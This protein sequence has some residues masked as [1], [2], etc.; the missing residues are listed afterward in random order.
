[1]K[2]ILTLT[3]VALIALFAIPTMVQAADTLQSKIDAATSGETITLD[4][5]YI[6][7]IVIKD[8]K[9]ITIDLSEFDIKGNT[10]NTI[11]VEIGSTLVIKGTTGEIINDN[12]NVALF[13]NGT[14]T[15]NGGIIRKGDEKLY[16]IVNHGTM[17]IN[18]GTIINE[19]PYV[20]GKSYASLI[21]NGYYNYGKSTDSSATGGYVN[22]VNSANPTL[23]INGGTFDGGRNTIKNDDGGVLTIEGGTFTNNI[24]VAVFN[25]NKATINGGTF[26]VPLGNDKTTIFNGKL[27]DTN[28]QGSLTVT[29]GEF[30]AEYLVETNSDDIG[31]TVKVIGGIFNISE[32]IVNPKTEENASRPDVSVTISG[33]EFE[34]E[35]DDKYVAT[36]L[37]VVE[38]NGIYYV[39]KLMAIK[40]EETE[41]GT[42]KASKDKAVQGQTVELTVTPN[43]GYKLKSLTV[44]TA[45]DSKVEVK[46]NKFTMPDLGVIVDAEF[47]KIPTTSGAAVAEPEKDDTPKTGSID[48]VL[49]ASAIIATIS[50]A[51]IVLVKKYT[52]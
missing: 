4:K 11:K 40:V 23:T 52:K 44:I 14:T 19:T 20:E 49:Y 35:I 34:S 21:E 41:N 32:G 24:Q 25:W 16:N 1:M 3:I 45:A 37:D 9:T 47:E 2:K 33:G 12:G 39:G 46:D 10:S 38:D 5:D 15:I 42:V 48:V 51:G 31:G 6:E 26:D 7:D 28:N 30:N 13:N 36:D 18:G 8:N 50:L 29:G 27:N 22:G 43:E 17:T